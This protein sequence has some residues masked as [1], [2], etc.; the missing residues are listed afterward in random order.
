M[1]RR[2]LSLVLGIAACAAAAPGP[3]YENLKADGEP[4]RTAFNEA[5]GRVRAIFL[6]SP[7]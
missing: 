3:T 5:H 6:A 4:L 2:W 7:T 1:E